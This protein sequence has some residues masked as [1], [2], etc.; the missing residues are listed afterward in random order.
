MHKIAVLVGSLQTN[1]INLKLAQSLEKLADGQ[2]KFEYVDMALP[3]FNQDLEADVPAAVEQARQVVADSDLVLFVTPEYNRSIP[4]V[5]KNVIDWLSRPYAKGVI[6]NKKAAIVGATWGKLGTSAAQSHL[7]A[8]V[9]SL[10]MP[11]MGRPEIYLNVT[12]ETFD[13][14]PQLADSEFAEKYVQALVEFIN[15]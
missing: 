9:G 5:L 3:L 11:L 6:I 12:A 10:N 8:I 14:G 7:R 1:S 15:R 13:D 2:L 4:G